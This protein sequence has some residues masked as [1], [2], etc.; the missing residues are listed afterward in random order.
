MLD[1]FRDWDDDN[2]KTVDKREFRKAMSA[3]GVGKGCLPLA[4]LQVAEE[5]HRRVERRSQALW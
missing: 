1:L 2:S 5:P 4:P 3:L